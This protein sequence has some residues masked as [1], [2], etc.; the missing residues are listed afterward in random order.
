[1]KLGLLAGNI[2]PRVRVNLEVIKHAETLGFDSVWTAEAWGGDAVTPATS[3]KQ[4]VKLPLHG[5][6]GSKRVAPKDTV[7]CSGL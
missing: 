2:G 3:S 5:R 6:I 1:M 4:N 7:F